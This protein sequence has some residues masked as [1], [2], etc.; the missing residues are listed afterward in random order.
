MFQKTRKNKS[1]IHLLGLLFLSLSAYT[2][3]SLA[4]DSDA[5]NRWRTISP[6]GVHSDWQTGTNINAGFTRHTI[7]VELFGNPTGNETQYLS[8]A[9]T[10]IDSITV[11]SYENGL[12]TDSFKLGDK[13][14]E[15]P[16]ITHVAG[17][18]LAPISSGTELVKLTI[19][20]TSSINLN[21]ELLSSEEAKELAVSASFIQGVVISILFVSLILGFSTALATQ[22]K[23]A[24][25]FTLYQLSWVVLISG[26]LSPMPFLPHNDGG[27]DS[28]VSFGAIFALIAGCYCHAQIFSELLSQPKLANLLKAVALAGLALLILLILGYEQEAL[29]VNVLIIS[30]VPLI[31]I[32]MLFRTDMRKQGS[33]L[34]G[35]KIKTIYILLMLSVFITGASGFGIG[36]LF[37]ITYIHAIITTLF[38]G[39]I[40]FL[41]LQEQS[42]KASLTAQ[43]LDLT[44]QSE[45]M[46]KQL[47]RDTKAFIAML[48]HEVKTPLTT[49]RFLNTHNPE[50]VKSEAQL[51]AIEKIINQTTLAAEIQDKSV[52]KSILSP[53][54]LVLK[55]WNETKEASNSISTLNIRCFHPLSISTDPFLA[56]VIVTNLISNARKYSD[57]KRD[58]RF[59]THQTDDSIVLSISNS[60]QVLSSD[61]MPMLFDKYWRSNKAQRFRGS[62]LGLWIVAKLADKLGWQVNASLKGTNLR[63]SLLIPKTEAIQ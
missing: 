45:A 8:I 53:E 11:E 2:N 32:G 37:N 34:N 49:L 46:T 63:I 6:E 39:Y 12:I 54:D 31:I 22:S 4:N 60:T 18:Y 42:K 14:E 38:L 44:K 10:Y 55:V 40:L 16:I 59:F 30:T 24:F 17:Q 13:K 15:D 25:G 23:A 62:G 29:K 9:P 20:S 47:L 3:D 56:L 33:A 21:P 36:P 43:T 57:A 52:K 19:H 35:R 50:K 51:D 48:A 41:G 61:D 58:V 1:L 7:E 27:N 26:I 28:L 5:T